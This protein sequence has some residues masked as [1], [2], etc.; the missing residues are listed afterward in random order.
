M[1]EAHLNVYEVAQAHIPFHYDTWKDVY[2]FVTLIGDKK[3]LLYTRGVL[4]AKLGLLLGISLVGETL[5]LALQQAS[6]ETIK[7]LLTLPELDNQWYC[8][9]QVTPPMV[10]GR[11]DV[12]ML[13]IEDGRCLK[14]TDS[15]LDNKHIKILFAASAR[16]LEKQILRRTTE[17]NHRD[18]L[19]TWLELS[20]GLGKNVRW[21]KDY[22]FP[23]TVIYAY[24]NT[25]VYIDLRQIAISEYF[26]LDMF[27][28]TGV[29]LTSL[30]QVEARRLE[31]IP[32]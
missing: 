26:G 9:V 21:G 23:K 25:V 13:L 14:Y 15:L 12:A 5:D 11:E 4:Y 27:S 3:H 28:S 22:R 17:Y 7:L 32:R 6:I 30:G 19:H 16:N 24:G 20:T 1:T 29:L 18:S 8:F 31:L 10:V 2:K